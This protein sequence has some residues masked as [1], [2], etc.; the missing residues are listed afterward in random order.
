MSKCKFYTDEGDAF[1]GICV[2]G[3]CPACADYCPVPEDP[4]YCLYSETEEAETE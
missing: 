1:D 2:N 4:D 3:G